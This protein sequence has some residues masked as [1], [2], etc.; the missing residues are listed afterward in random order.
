MSTI[1]DKIYTEIYNDILDGKL[2][3]RARLNIAE[4]ATRYGATL[5]PVREA[6]GKLTA[7]ELVVAIPQKGFRVA[8]VSAADLHDIYETRFQIEAIML[9]L[10]IEKGDDAWEAEVIG[11][12]HRLEQ[13]EKKCPFQSLKEYQQWEALHRAFNLALLSACKLTH[14]LQIQAKIYGQTERYRRMWVRAALHAEKNL[15][16]AEKQKAIML[17][18]L[19]RDATTAVSLLQKHFAQAVKLINIDNYNL[20]LI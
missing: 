16:F 10:A 3:P 7:T 17:A 1:C 4:L 12:Q 13:F 2:A 8:A 6:L 14:L 5:S 19:K 18:A 20:K 9:K 11:T 15:R